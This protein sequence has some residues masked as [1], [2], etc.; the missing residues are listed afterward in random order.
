MHMLFSPVHLVEHNNGNLRSV[1]VDS[2]DRLSGLSDS[3][4][5]SH[6]LIHKNILN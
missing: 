3:G 1:M 4:Y 5:R 6:V 2:R